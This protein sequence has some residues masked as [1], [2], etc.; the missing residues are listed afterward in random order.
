MDAVVAANPQSYKSYLARW[1]YRRNFD[2]LRDPGLSRDMQALVRRY[3]PGTV[4]ERLT[5]RRAGTEAIL[6]RAGEDVEA[7]IKRAPEEL[8]VLL[9]AA[10]LE[11]LKGAC[12]RDA[13]TASQ[14]RK[15]ARGYLQ[16][17]LQLQSKQ[18]YRG[19][20]DQAKFHLLWH[21][22]NLLLDSRQT[23]ETASGTP[24]PDHKQ[25]LDEAADAI[26]Q[27][28]QL[29]PLPPGTLDYLEG[30]LFREQSRWAEAAARFEHARPQFA[31]RGELV[32]EIDLQLG[33]CY[34]KLEEPGLMLEAYERAL[35]WDSNSAVARIGV[36]AA[37]WSMGRA[38]EAIKSYQTA[39]ER[40]QVPAEGWKDVARLHV[41]VQLS[42]EDRDWKEAEAAIARAEA[43]TPKLVELKLLH[44]EVLAAQEKF[45]EAEEFLVQAL[46]ETP[47]EVDLW[48]ARAGLAEHPKN[49]DSDP[50]AATN[51]LDAAVQQAG[52]RVELRLARARMVVRQLR[53][54]N[55]KEPVQDAAK[56]KHEAATV[57]AKMEQKWQEF[58]P[59]DQ[60]KLLDGLAEAYFVSGDVKKAR[61]LWGKVAQMPM[62]Q[63]D[64]RLRL[65]LFDLAIKDNDKDG[66]DQ[67]LADIDAIEHGQGVYHRFGQALR[68]IWLAKQPRAERKDALLNE[69]RLLL[70]QAANKRPTWSRIALA[71]AEIEAMRGNPEEAIT[72]LKKAIEQ[73]ETSPVV[74]QR[75][76]DALVQRQRYAEADQELERLRKSM[77]VNSELGRL[78]ASVALRRGNPDRALE[79]AETAVDPESKNFRDLV[80]HARLLFVADNEQEAFK[81]IHQ[82][83][84]M[85]DTEPEPYVAMVQFLAAKRKVKEAMTVVNQARE[86]LPPDKAP[87]ALAQCYEALGMGDDA[88]KSYDTAIKQTPGDVSVLRTAAGFYL[89]TGNKNDV[90]PLL[91]AVVNGQVAASQENVEW[92]RRGLAIVLASSRNYEQYKEALQLVGL[93][94]NDNGQLLRDNARDAES[95]DSIRA[96]ARVL[97]SQCDQRQFRERAIELLE[98]L[99]RRGAL[100]PDD[101]YIL[102]VLYEAGD[103]WPKSREQLKELSMPL[104]Q[105]ENPRYLQQAPQFM[106]R[107]VLGLLHNGDFQEAER[108]LDRLD[109]IEKQHG[110]KPGT[111][112]TIELR[113]QLLEKTGEAD[114]ALSLLQDY[115]AHNRD[116]KNIILVVVAGLA[117]QKRYQ[118]ALAL[119][120]RGVTTC[121][122]ESATA[123][124]VSLL[125][126]MNPTDEQC[127]KVESWLKAQLQA[128]EKQLSQVHESNRI[129]ELKGTM[130]VLRHGLARLYDLR[131][132]YADSEAVYQAILND[133]QTDIL[134]LNN[135]SWLLAQRVGDG[136]TALELID[137]A[138]TNMGRRADLLD[139]RGLAY[140]SLG[141]PDKALAD[142]KEAAADERTPTRLFHLARAH[143]AAKDRATALKV[144]LDA[145]SAGLEPSKLHPV[146]QL[147]CRELMTELKVQ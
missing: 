31:K 125:N 6:Q 91:R 27:L 133:Q 70:D 139:T 129:Q 74:I 15:E 83:I 53:K 145:K 49:P 55:P 88:R 17:G 138:I 140:L 92:A 95:T 100:Q 47:N 61:E 143:F 90:V 48:V 28:R 66:I 108:V 135:L 123:V 43:V 146:E 76:V 50:E 79:L 127:L 41:L 44:A 20:S 119:L 87:L 134:A 128:A 22:A 21:L 3:A 34:E 68:Q 105:G 71:R 116:H 23:E 52:D 144:M 99:G 84:A 115:A 98:T 30:R 120:D 106:P 38:E 113:A 57:L 104:T 46:S 82:A 26:A 63:A 42:R 25:D 110:V 102:A 13:Q 37:L 56:R 121:H 117:R 59:A 12:S 75:L 18:G 81:K 132:R 80:W 24:T 7:A 96:K 73:G 1:H 36:G 103:V 114:K 77:K 122:V 78:A 14:H 60:S 2:L 142:F 147:S 130:T 67:T 112:G 137:R 72:C 85:A 141:E 107:Y 5:D 136:K 64:L 54:A 40:D 124:Y 109:A 9:A 69:A 101:K 4:G 33:Q 126:E 29:R 39:M 35:K 16:L 62:N 51:V 97:A 11:R 58:K 93:K 118:E 19:A 10:D 94:L 89:K 111:F 86:K 131:G 32:Y 45:K 65:L 8:D